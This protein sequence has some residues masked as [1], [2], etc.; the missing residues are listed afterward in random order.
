M[1]RCAV[2][3]P[4]IIVLLW[5]KHRLVE[6]LLILFGLPHI[7]LL[8]VNDDP[9]LPLHDVAQ[10]LL[11]HLLILGWLFFNQLLGKSRWQLD[12]RVLL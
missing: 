9:K 12:V 11:D 4:V 5:S 7:R 2:V 3:S 8:V 10:D 1:P 6:H